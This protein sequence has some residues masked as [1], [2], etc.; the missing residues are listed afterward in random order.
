M[1][2]ISCL[3]ELD[4]VPWGVGHFGE[5]LASQ[6]GESVKLVRVANFLEGCQSGDRAKVDKMANFSEGCQRATTPKKICFFV[7][8][9]LGFVG[10]LDKGRGGCQRDEVYLLFPHR[11]VISTK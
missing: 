3:V 10:S 8:F 6:F 11:L 4:T 7:L 5:F 9:F 1:M 2:H